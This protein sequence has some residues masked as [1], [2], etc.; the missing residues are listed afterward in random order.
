MVS[1]ATALD[2]PVWK[3]HNDP[4]PPF[5]KDKIDL[6]GCHSPNYF[7]R[8]VPGRPEVC[9]FIKKETLAQV[10]SWEFCEILRN[11]C[12]IKKAVLENFAKFTGN[13]LY[14]SLFFNK[15]ASWKPAT[16]IKMRLWSRSSPENFAKYFPKHRAFFSFISGFSFTNINDSQDNRR[17]GRLFLSLL[18]TTST[19]ITDT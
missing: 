2:P 19:H 8:L 7:S 1:V 5:S 15:V 11:I 10:F 14:Q 9:N 3:V 16:L 4:K 17:R 12:S 13:H 6:C 18:C